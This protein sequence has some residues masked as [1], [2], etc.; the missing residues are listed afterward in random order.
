MGLD[1]RVRTGGQ[2]DQEQFIT[3]HINNVRKK[4]GNVHIVFIPEN[5]LSMDGELAGSY[6]QYNMRNTTVMEE[7]SKGNDKKYGVIKKAG[8]DRV[9][10]AYITHYLS[11]GTLAIHQHFRSST[12]KNDK[13]KARN[14]FVGQMRGFKE[15]ARMP[16]SVHGNTSY[17]LAGRKDGKKEGK[18]DCIIVLGMAL[19]W[20]HTFAADAK[21][22]SIRQ[23]YGRR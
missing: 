7:T 5:N 22:A 1:A 8:D 18:D 17:K 3:S 20:S 16:L 2:F 21:Y 19:R 6:V 10:A 11:T 14:I 12:F 4:F 9:M 13:E 23:L 15:H